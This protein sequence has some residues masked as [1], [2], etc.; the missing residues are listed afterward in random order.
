LVGE[1][2][3]SGQGRKHA[4]DLMRRDLAHLPG[5]NDHE[6]VRILFVP[7]LPDGRERIGDVHLADAGSV[8]R[9]LRD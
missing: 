7:A 4:Y 2:K 6:I 8:L 9:S 5:I 3:W 1:A